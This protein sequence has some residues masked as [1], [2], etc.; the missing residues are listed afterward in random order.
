MKSLFRFALTV[1]LLVAVMAAFP[2]ISTHAQGAD[3][4][5]FDLQE[6]DCTM[7][8]GA[9][10]ADNAVQ[11]TKGVTL[12]YSLDLKVGGATPA[13]VNV[14]GTGVAGGTG[15]AALFSTDLNLSSN[16][17]DQ[18]MTLP[19]QLRVVNKKVY[20]NSAM[21]TQGKWNFLA[22]D[23]A[24]SAGGSGASL[25]EQLSGLGALAGGGASGNT[26]AMAA[27]SDP[28]V[29]AA[30]AKA[31][32]S[33]GVVTSAV[34]DAKATDGTAVKQ[35]VFTF[36]AAKMIQSPEFRPALEKMVVASPELGTDADAV[37]N[38][39]AD[40]LKDTSMVFGFQV[41]SDDKLLH[42]VALHIAS[43][44]PEATLKEISKD[45]SS[46]KGDLDLD[47]TFKLDLSNIGTAPTVE[48]PTDATEFDFSSMFGGMSGGGLGSG[49]SGSSG[50]G[51]EATETTTP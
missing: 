28:E 27:A 7:L 50:S 13:S 19:L 11:Y 36:N 16:S 34:T 15:D 12:A 41:G 17:N 47:L 46:V 31:F 26:A 43:K 33:P 21:F 4:P 5:C 8:Y 10:S 35:I 37:S 22:L 51:A 29:Q 42:G 48:E 3:K 25:Q 49:S 18:K 2:A 38:K 24:T 20:F 32:M 9:F 6:A 14:T 23:K 44:I 1:L 39:L 30:V 45:S 40:A